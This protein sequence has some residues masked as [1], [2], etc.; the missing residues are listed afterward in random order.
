M[1]TFGIEIISAQDLSKRNLP[2]YDI[3]RSMDN[4]LI[5]NMKIQQIAYISKYGTAC[6]PGSIVTI[7]LS[8][9]SYI[10]DG[11][12]REQVIRDLINEGYHLDVKIIVETYD[13]GSD[14]DLARAVYM[15][16]IVKRGQGVDVSRPDQNLAVLINNTFTTD[17]Q[18]V[19]QSS[20]HPNNSGPCTAHNSES[21]DASYGRSSSEFNRAPHPS[22]DTRSRTEFNRAPGPSLD[23]RSS[24]ESNRATGHTPDHA[25]DRRSGPEFKS[26][27][28][29]ASNTRSRAEFN[30]AHH[31]SFD[32]RFGAEFNSAQHRSSDTRF[33]AEFN[34]AH[35][36]PSALN[37]TRAPTRKLDNIHASEFVGTSVARIHHVCDGSKNCTIHSRNFSENTYLTQQHI[38]N[39]DIYFYVTLTS[40]QEDGTEDFLSKTLVNNF[41]KMFPPSRSASA[42]VYSLNSNNGNPILYGLI[43]YDRLN[44]PPGTRIS[45]KSNHIK[46]NFKSHGTGNI[47]RPR[48]YTV[49]N[50]TVYKNKQYL[51]RTDIIRERYNSIVVLGN[52]V[53]SSIDDFL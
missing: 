9:I 36:P 14:R 29:P 25:F 49:E 8:G 13:C 5:H 1:A 45:P 2:I 27:T 26:A 34:S 21:S 50:L 23:I 38:M 4:Q 41:M 16:S 33:G 44:F 18:I 20:G 43:R 46:N 42:Y 3:Q 15:F 51:T 40:S 39:N 10:A 37:S 53:G 11:Q 19:T 12:H 48:E 17:G 31:R 7:K 24:P 32:T 52:A 22:S 35:Y 28:H 47:L 6:F 30:G